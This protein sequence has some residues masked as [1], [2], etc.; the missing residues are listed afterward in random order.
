MLK[1]TRNRYINMRDFLSLRHAMFAAIAMMFMSGTSVVIATDEDNPLDRANIEVS[2][3]EVHEVLSDLADNITSAESTLNEV[4]EM[5]VEDSIRTAIDVFEKLK[6]R[7]NQTLE[8]LGP[9]SVMM[10]NL[11]GAKT[12]VIVLQSWYERQ[13]ADYPKRDTQI[14]RLGEALT[15]YDQLATQ[16][17]KLRE[18]AQSELSRIAYDQFVIEQEGKVAVVDLSVSETQAVVASLESVLSTM[19]KLKE[20]SV[21]SSIPE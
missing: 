1:H 18:D 2:Y 20:Q 13:P 17:H 12:K 8:R 10:D 5:S 16:I 21:P 3:T 6:E 7:L 19:R 15:D 4:A 11:E 14:M 9:N